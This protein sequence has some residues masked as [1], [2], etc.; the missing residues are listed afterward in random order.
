[1]VGKNLPV[2]YYRCS[3]KQCQRLLSPCFTSR[4]NPPAAASPSSSSA[5]SSRPVAFPFSLQRFKLYCSCCCTE[6]KATRRMS[7]QVCFALHSRR[8]HFTIIF[9]HPTT[10][11]YDAPTA[12][13]SS[14]SP[15]RPISRSHCP[16]FPWVG[17]STWT[18]NLVLATM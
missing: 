2:W 9:L 14:P 15:S 6:R 5:P 17:L 13:F 8:S 7:D 12:H 11:Y 10:T 1:M 3:D 16:I 18:L 4:R